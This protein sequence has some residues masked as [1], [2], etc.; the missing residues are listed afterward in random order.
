MKNILLSVAVSLFLT[1]CAG[2]SKDSL[3]PVAVES[4]VVFKERISQTSEKQ[5]GWTDGFMPGTYK[6]IGVDKKGT[7]YMGPRFGRIQYAEGYEDQRCDGGFFVPFDKTQTM[8]FFYIMS[9]CVIGKR[10]DYLA[11]HPEEATEEDRQ[12]GIGVSTSAFGSMSGSTAGSVGVGVGVGVAN[13]L[14]AAEQGKI[15][16]SRDI[17]DPRIIEIIRSQLKN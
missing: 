2:V 1:A 8:T 16:I 13:G 17:E 6:A 14:I 9:P 12:A 7:Y 4:S 15:F 10:V 5:Y 11:L 3:K